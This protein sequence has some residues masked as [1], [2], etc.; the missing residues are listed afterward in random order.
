MNQI[1]VL[2]ADS[3]FWLRLILDR[4]NPQEIRVITKLRQKEQFKTLFK[5]VLWTTAGQ[6]C[7]ETA[8]VAYTRRSL[9]TEINALAKKVMECGACTIVTRSGY[10]TYVHAEKTGSGLP[11]PCVLYA[12]MFYLGSLTR[13]KP[14]DF[15]KINAGYAWLIG[16]FLD[17]QPAQFLSYVASFIAGTEVVYPLAVRTS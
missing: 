7:L 12:A 10:R 9:D 8:P 14:Y 2:K 6:I 16:E 13:Y 5:Q 1:S 15:D 3:K 4:A 17:T 11:Q